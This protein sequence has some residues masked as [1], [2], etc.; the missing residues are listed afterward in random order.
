MPTIARPI[1]IVAWSLVVAATGLPVRGQPPVPVGRFADGT[2]VSGSFAAWHATGVEPQFAGRRIL[3][4][5]PLRWAVD[6]GQPDDAAP[7]SYV[8][9]DNGDRLPGVVEGYRSGRESL[10]QRLPPHLLVRPLVPVDSAAVQTPR[11]HIRVA[12]GSVSR[13]VARSRSG[14]LAE[15]GRLEL[16]SDG[17]VIR[18]R[19]LRWTPTGVL[20]LTEEGAKRIDFDG[21]ADLVMPAADPWETW[22]DAVARVAPDPA[23]RLLRS[24][25]ASGLVVTAPLDTLQAAGT[26]GNPATWEHTVQPAWSLEPL[27]LRYP[28]IRTRWFFT[29]HEVPL[30]LIDV[31]RVERTS[32]FG[33]SWSWRRNRC[34][35]GGMLLANG[36]PAGWGFGV[37]AGCELFFPLPGIATGFRS[38]VALD[39]AAGSG[40]CIQASVRLD[41]ASAQ[42]LWQGP[43]IVGSAIARSTGPA[44]TGP[45]QLPPTRPDGSMLVLAAD[46]AHKGRPAAADPFDIR[47]FTDWL[48]PLVLLDPPRLAEIVQARL[49]ATI[50]AWKDWNVSLPAGGSLVMRNLPSGGVFVRR[51]IARGGPLVLG[52]SVVVT[53]DVRFVVLGVSREKESPSR[54]EVRVDGATVATADVP[55]RPA[56]KSI[57]PFL[58]PL[59]RF[60]GETVKLEVVHVPSDDKALVEW[61][62]L[63]TSGPLASTW[64]PLE[65]VDA[66]TRD[67]TV[68]TKLEDGS[69]LASGP[70]PNHD[71]YT[72][73]LRTAQQGITGLR[74]DSLEHPS[75]PRG[76]PSRFGNGNRNF[77]IT[78]V[79]ITAAPSGKPDAARP[80]ALTAAR[81]TNTPPEWLQAAHLIDADP[82][83]GWCNTT[84]A[85]SIVV[86]FAEPAGFQ[87][88]TEFVVAL[89]SEHAWTQHLLGRFRLSTTTAAHPSFDLP[90]VLLPDPS[91]AEP[92]AAK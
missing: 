54:I 79:A 42:P 81:A 48:D 16:A 4:G 61:H 52:R 50:P 57:D 87:E 76:G 63:E 46:M 92:P 35:Q 51:V 83:S 65:V 47:D 5:S 40:G 86:T 19:S 24:E 10:D 7:E 13:I 90:G 27:C 32:V 69:V 39:D 75:M 31:A 3:V 18:F 14:R 55:E 38:Q 85:A 91:A 34:V 6:R 56:G 53:P 29:P 88:G 41:P 43:M 23:S 11:K 62:V 45:I 80:V 60:A 12:A 84:Q 2:T 21:I 26:P 22:F 44:D 82:G 71:V 89:A 77:V 66:A 64:E 1:L 36:M 15:P 20:L 70:T 78:N 73:R 33:G 59:E 17:S 37:Q 30:P 49:P 8:E 25:T 58:V 9:C 74:L 28:D 72:I 67:G 68:L